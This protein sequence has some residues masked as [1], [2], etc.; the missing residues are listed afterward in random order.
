MS[1]VA[2]P[3]YPI[4]EPFGAAAVNPADITLPIPIPSQIGVLVGAAS[5]ADGFPAATRTDPESGGVPPYGQ[6]MNGILFMLSQYAA[7]MQA[8]QTVQFDAAVAAAIGGYAVGA[9]VQSAVS[10]T[11]FFLNV[12]DGNTNDPDSVLTGWRTYSPLSLATGLQTT[13]LATGVTSDLPLVAGIGFLDLNPTTGAS[14]L[15]GI[16]ATN[17]V[18]GQLLVISNINGGNAVTLK[19]LDIG[20][21]ASARFRLPADI[22][23]LQYSNITLRHSSAIGLWVPAS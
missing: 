4:T 1:G 22:T 17:V 21:A 11:T 3:Q 23:L 16:D 2:T 5:F 7:L 14:N 6:D 13:V 9:M 18:D 20:S 10:L 8:G 19:A 15:T 12:L